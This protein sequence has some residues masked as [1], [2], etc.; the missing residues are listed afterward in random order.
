V[1]RAL[2]DAAEFRGASRRPLLQAAGLS[3]EQLADDEAWLLLSVSDRICEV[4]MEL[5]GDPAF[6]LH[7]GAQLT[8]S[9][10]P[11]ITN[12]FMH[13]TS[14]RDAFH[15]IR[16]FSR[17][18]SDEVTLEVVE[19]LDDVVI[20]RRA[21]F[22]IGPLSVRRFRAEMFAA[23]L[24]NQIRRLVPH[25]RP[26]V[27]SFEHPEPHYHGEYSRLFGH[28]ARFNQAFT[29]IVFG[30]ALMSR[31][32]PYR[33]AE[34]ATALH[35]LAE[36]RLLRLARSAPYAQ[37]VREAILRGGWPDR[38]DMQSVARSLG[39]SVRSLRRRL[40]DEGRSYN[41]V[42]SDA[43]ASLAKEMLREHSRSIQE[44]SVA[45]GYADKSTFHRAFKQWTGYTPDAYR[46][47][48]APGG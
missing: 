4:V 39:I 11:P 24:L 6:G 7:W 23:G 8:E 1:I 10:F 38:V 41:A 40:G 44:I 19:E 35:S 31:R 33:D 27:V 45:M 37:R 12:L 3:E 9:S 18:L 22:M 5:T 34:I 13:A 28:A 14:V 36:R 47:G 16:R 32:S 21:D 46:R 29:G 42:L 17:L 2:I 30:S 15:T 20:V 26:L 48:C 25:L 43:L